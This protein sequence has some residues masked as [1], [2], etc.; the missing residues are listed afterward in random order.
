LCRAQGPNKTTPLNSSI[1]AIKLMVHI[2]PATS[3]S[4]VLIW[5]HI[6]FTQHY[7]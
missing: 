2:S 5:Q 6:C 3:K 1:N 7:S 4:A